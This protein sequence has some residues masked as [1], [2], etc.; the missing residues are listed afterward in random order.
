MSFEVRC[1]ACQRV[2]TWE[3][4]PE[5]HRVE[6]RLEGGSRRP[7]EPAP[8]AAWRTLTATLDTPGQTVLGACE[9]C[10]QPRI[11]ATS[12]VASRPYRLELDRGALVFSDGGFTGP[13]GPLDAQE[14]LAFVRSQLP[15]AERASA[16]TVAFTSV[17]AGIA[18][19]IAVAWVFAFGFFLFFVFYGAAS[20]QIF[21]PR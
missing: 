4:E 12:E 18:A 1:P 15:P 13:S 3:A 6:V 9:A 11:A 10:G 14:A 8:V 17:A 2:E 7:R 21:Q 16:G 20:G 5:P 19:I